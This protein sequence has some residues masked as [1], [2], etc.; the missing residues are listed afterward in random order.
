M[1]TA[2]KDDIDKLKRQILFYRQ[3]SDDA[4]N[5]MSTENTLLRSKLYK[6]G[7]ST[8]GTGHVL[9]EDV[10]D[11]LKYFVNLKNDPSHD[12]THLTNLIKI[13]QRMNEASTA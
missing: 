6:Y 3:K 10:R 8:E 11:A 9:A 4:T 7:E 13:Y 5:A 12:Q 2:L 1:N